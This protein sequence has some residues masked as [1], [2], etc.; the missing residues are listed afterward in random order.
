MDLSGC[1]P[2]V[3][4]TRVQ[5]DRGL[6]GEWVD[7]DHVLTVV[8][9]GRVDIVCD[10]LRVRAGPGCAVLMPP[11]LRHM[12]R[13]QPGA[14]LVQHVVHFDLAWHPRRAAQRRTGLASIPAGYPAEASPLAG[15]LPV[16][17]LPPPALIEARAAFAELRRACAGERPADLLRRQAS[18]LQ[19]IALVLEHESGGARPAP[20]ARPSRAWATLDRA[21]R[22][23]HA[24]LDDPGLDIAAIADAAR[25]SA[26]YLPELFRAQLGESVRRYLL[27]LRIRRASELLAGGATVTAVAAATGFAGIHAFSRAFRRVA[28]IPPSAVPPAVPV[29][30][31]GPAAD[32]RPG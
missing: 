18:L 2:W 6:V 31:L 15:R 21:V 28:G 5:E 10:G 27:H 13:T 25:V 20:P 16:A 8:H 12:V 22:H 32:P 11:L 29:R 26:A 14:T 9:R 17:Q 4:L 19:L 3:R 1:S 7:F 30:E 24:C 23:M